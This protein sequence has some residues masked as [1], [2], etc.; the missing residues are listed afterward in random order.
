MGINTLL[1]YKGGNQFLTEGGDP[2]F[3]NVRFL[4]SLG[5][6]EHFVAHPTEAE[7]LTSF[8]VLLY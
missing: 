1:N 3:L 6:D 2:A 8:P 7:F 5:A 4:L